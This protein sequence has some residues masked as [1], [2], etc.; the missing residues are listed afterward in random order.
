MW[1]TMNIPREVSDEAADALVELAFLAL[2][3]DG[4]EMAKFLEAILHVVAREVRR[5]VTEERQQ[6]RESIQ[7]VS[8]Q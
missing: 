6:R 1:W 4:N 2:P 8:L 7:K 5:A 3:S